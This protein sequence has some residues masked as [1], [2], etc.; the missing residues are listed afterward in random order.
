MNLGLKY[1]SVKLIGSKPTI[2]CKINGTESE[3]LLDTGSQV[4]M[5]DKAWLSTHAPG[6]EMKPVA[7][8]L[9]QGEEVKFMA[10]NNAEVQITGA[11]ILDFTMGTCSFPVPFVV[12]EGSMSQPL[13]G[14]NVM[15][16][17]VSL[18][19]SDKIVSSLHRAMNILIY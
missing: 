16:H 1:R 12:T 18:G 15:D 19:N 3:V 4:S 10:A 6:V 8:F 11:V 17:I 2:N 13:L 5:C 14:F 7:E 9:E